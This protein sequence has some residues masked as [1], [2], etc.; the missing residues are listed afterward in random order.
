MDHWV[1]CKG[2]G[3][4][5]L[6]H[7]MDP[8]TLKAPRHFGYQGAR[9]VLPKST[10]ISPVNWSKAHRQRVFACRYITSERFLDSVFI[11]LVGKIRPYAEQS[12]LKVENKPFLEPRGPC[13]SFHTRRSVHCESLFPPQPAGPRGGTNKSKQ[14]RSRRSREKGIWEKDV[15]SK[16]TQNR[17]PRGGRVY[18]L[19]HLKNC[20]PGRTF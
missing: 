18:L 10:A 11:S 9:A 16:F 13:S 14:A 20:F 3:D 6:D 7:I 1:G 12:T 17:E 15:C 2:V 19:T 4:K 5:W 8:K